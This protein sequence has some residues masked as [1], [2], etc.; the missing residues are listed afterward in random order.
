MDQANI[1]STSSPS[2]TESRWKWIALSCFV[3]LV[4][5]I[6]WDGMDRR[7]ADATAPLPHSPAPV[8]SDQAP[9]TLTIAS[10][11]IHGGKGT[12][13]VRSVSRIADLLGGVDYAGLY[14]VRGAGSRNEPNQAASV[15]ELNRSGWLFAATERRWWSDHFGNGLLY[16]I[17]IRSALRIPLVNTRGKAYRNAILATVP[18]QQGDVRVLSVHI[19]REKDRLHQLQAMIDL[20][21]GLQPPCILM[22]DL[23]TI[24]GDPLLTSLLERPGVH[25]PLHESLPERLSSQNID[26]IFTRGLETVNVSLVQNTA[27][28]HPVVKGEFRLEGTKNQPD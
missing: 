11:N 7:A 21:L 16:R 27:S 25:S 20:F 22:G 17:P 18:L 4:G 14:E 26:W 15:A 3:A 23:N 24:A 13:G 6:L 9:A 5:L 19:D 1:S 8:G 12:D 28:D 10:F 2:K